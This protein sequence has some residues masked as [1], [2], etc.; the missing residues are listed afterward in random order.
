MP[1]RIDLIGKR[2]GRW[3]VTAYAR[4]SKWCCVC[5]CGT[6]VD[7]DGNNLRRGKTKSCG[8]RR[9]KV[10]VIKHGMCESREYISWQSMKSRCC[11]P[12]SENY[13][14]YG[15]RGISLCEDWLSFEAFFA[16]MGPRPAG[17]SLDRIDPNGDYEP[18]N[19]RW[20]D[21]KQQRQNQRPRPARAAVKRRQVE[22]L[23]PPLNSPPF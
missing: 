14:N 19:C 15:G 9:G 22:P 7:V 20:S 17:C 6:R 11:N 1:K 4:N 21:R 8:Y 5:D 10:G 2:F 23:P 3:V 13:E 16:D 18:S 12:R